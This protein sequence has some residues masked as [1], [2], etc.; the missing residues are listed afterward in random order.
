MK[1]ICAPESYPFPTDDTSLPVVLY[2]QA[3]HS[4]RGSV[5]ATVRHI[6]LRQKLI[7]DPRAWDFL[8]LALS[9]TAADLAGHRN[10][11][12]DG[13]T[14]EF[15]LEVAVADPAFWN[16]QQA[17]IERLLA[18]LSTDRWHVHFIEGG[19][20]L[21][22]PIDPVQPQEDCVVLLS[23]GLD[24]LIGTIDLVTSGKQPFAVSQ[25]VRGDARRQEKFTR[26][27]GHGLRHLQLNHNARV[28]NPEMPPTQRA[29][30]L[31]FLAYGVLAATTLATYQADR[32]VPLYMCENGFISV[33]PPL[34]GGRLGSLSTRTTHPLFLRGVQDVLN[35]AGLHV[36]IENPYQLKTKG[37]MLVGCSDQVRLE[38]LAMSSTSCGRFKRY[39]YK[40]CGR[41]VPCQIR[42]AAFLTWGVKDQTEYVFEDL[43][44][45]DAEHAGFDDVRSVAMAIAQ[46]QGE[47]IDSWLGSTLSTILLPDVQQL[48]VVVQRGLNELAALHQVHG[49]V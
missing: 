27:I 15:A 38:E 42:R 29:R 10:R 16:S 13:W 28:P 24:S 37:E 8:S 3:S 23:G 21:A 6:M 4:E 39:G 17:N 31:V 45:D 35:N 43:G 30:S 12:A 40:H 7:A 46:V 22:P 33:N 14:R 25:L 26:S 41:C 11:S 49:V 2:G 18:F 1:L 9:V 36:Q 48:K 34:T 44:K 5:G 19:I 32:V 47:G 20:Q